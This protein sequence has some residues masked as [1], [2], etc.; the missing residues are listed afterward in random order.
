MYYVEQCM[1][2]GTSDSHGLITNAAHY[3]TQG[4]RI[5]LIQVSYLVL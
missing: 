1:H 5:V 2:V 3:I 4:E